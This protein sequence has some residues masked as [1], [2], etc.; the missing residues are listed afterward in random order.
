MEF[1]ELRKK[2]VAILDSEDFTH[3]EIITAYSQALVSNLEKID[4]TKNESKNL[5]MKIGILDA[6]AR[7]IESL[8]SE[9]CDIKQR[10]MARSNLLIDI[11]DIWITK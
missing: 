1:I 11:A 2:F 7:A 4:E 3:G 6:A 9:H 8:S 10:R 5:E